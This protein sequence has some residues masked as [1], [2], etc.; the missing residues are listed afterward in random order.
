MSTDTWVIILNENSRLTF[1]TKNT[2]FHLN[3]IRFCSLKVHKLQDLIPVACGNVECKFTSESNSVDF[4]GLT[5]T[6]TGRERTVSSC[7]CTHWPQCD[8]PATPLYPATTQLDRS[9][10]PQI[11]DFTW[12][13]SSSRYATVLCIRIGFN[14]ALTDPN[15]QY[16][17]SKLQNETQ[18]LGGRATLVMECDGV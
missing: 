11:K 2:S 7:G 17:S 3:K 10:I 9:T 15:T 14:R 16:S 12:F 5:H 6:H 13:M 4:R 18:R 1:W 8:H